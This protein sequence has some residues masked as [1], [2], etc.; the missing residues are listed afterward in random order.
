MF[1]LSMCSGIGFF[2]NTFDICRTSFLLSDPL[3]QC[4]FKSSIEHFGFVFRMCLQVYWVELGVFYAFWKN[5]VSRQMKMTELEHSLQEQ[6]QRIDQLERK[7]VSWKTSAVSGKRNRTPEGEAT[8]RRDVSEKKES[9]CS[10]Y[11]G[12]NTVNSA[13]VPSSVP[14]TQRVCWADS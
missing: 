12:N 4:S 2:K 1:T 8:S 5:E 13:D 6:R 3:D 14:H 10:K 7:K 9:C 11:L